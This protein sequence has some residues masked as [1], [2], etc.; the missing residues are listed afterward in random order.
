M[1]LYIC[2]VFLAVIP[3]KAGIQDSLFLKNNGFSP[4]RVAEVTRLLPRANSR[5]LKRMTIIGFFQ[6]LPYVKLFMPHYI[7]L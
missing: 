5:R 2:S 7:S 4:R 6:E 1:L 3:A